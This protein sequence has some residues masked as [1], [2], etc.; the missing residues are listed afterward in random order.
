MGKAKAR[1]TR[2]LQTR[3]LTLRL[4]DRFIEGL[5]KAVEA[6]GEGSVTEFIR[7]AVFEKAAQYGVK[8]ER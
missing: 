5:E 8:V 2:P 4:S 7:R 6:S 1:R 3:Q